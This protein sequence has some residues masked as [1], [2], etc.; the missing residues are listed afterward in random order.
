MLSDHGVEQ[1][2]TT[3]LN[4]KSGLRVEHQ[5]RHGYN[6]FIFFHN[7]SVVKEFWEYKKAL[8]FAEG[9]ALGRLLAVASVDE[10]N[11]YKI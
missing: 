4:S 10:Y 7:D 1:R 3:T 5:C 11:E 6:V 9:V 2:L 8:A